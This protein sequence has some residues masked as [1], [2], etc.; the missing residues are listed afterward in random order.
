M[1]IAIQPNSIIELD[2]TIVSPSGTITSIPDDAVMMP[3]GGILSSSGTVLVQA[4][5]INTS[6][7]SNDIMLNN[8]AVNLAK[9]AINE[10]KNDSNLSWNVNITDNL[11]REVSILVSQ[12]YANGMIPEADNVNL[13]ATF[14]N[15]P[16]SFDLSANK[17]FTLGNQFASLDIFTNEGTP[18]IQIFNNLMVIVLNDFINTTPTFEPFNF[19]L[20]AIY[21][22]IAI[23]Q[24]DN[25]KYLSLQNTIINYTAKC[26]VKYLANPKYLR[27]IVS[28]ANITQSPAGVA[29]DL[30]NMTINTPFTPYVL[31]IDANGTPI[32]QVTSLPD[33]YVL[34]LQSGIYGQTP[35]SLGGIQDTIPTSIRVPGLV[36]MPDRNI[37][38]ASNNIIF[39]SPPNWDMNWCVVFD[40]GSVA[41]PK[42]LFSDSVL[43]GGKRNTRRLRKKGKKTRRNYMV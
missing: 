2:G 4:G 18:N 29:T 24:G 41:V 42:G 30:W 13:L 36:L 25:S 6:P 11:I 28:A 7:L 21:T 27:I 31:K 40:D 1:S 37:Y 22:G 10:Y 17:E 3:D 39:S 14:L 5:T 8:Q 9:S 15:I 12:L 26:I 23:T 16:S 35:D 33:N 19:M 43:S 34:H 20:V 32:N 38:D